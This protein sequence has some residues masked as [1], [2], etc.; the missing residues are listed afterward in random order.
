MAPGREAS[1]FVV[2]ALALVLGCSAPPRSP[3]NWSVA[4]DPGDGVSVSGVW[5]SAPEDVFAVGGGETGAVFHF[6]GKAW[7]RME[8]PAGSGLLAWVFGFGRDDVYAVGLHGLVLHYDGHA[9]T[10]LE[11]GTDA[12]LWG[13]FG[14]AKNDV[15]MVGGDPFAGPP[16]LLHFDGTTFT[17]VTLPAS[18]NPVHALSLFK[19]WGIGGRTWAVGQRGLIVELV[20]GAWKRQPAGSLADEDFISLWGVDAAHVTAV[21]GR[22]NARVARFDGSTWDTVAPSALGGLNAVFAWP[23][24]SVF[25]GGTSG[26]AGVLDRATGKVTKDTTGTHID[27]HAM[28]GDGKGHLYA[29]GGNFISPFQG[30]AL[31]RA[32]P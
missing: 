6:D 9:W 30:I 24:G 16:L 7:S 26:V 23:D 14:H 1:P 22:G 3:A 25:A 17:Q 19:V 31:V 32:V 28:W 8:L 2:L 4:F 20:D 11:T 5:G 29:V 10:R 27:V 15:W 12:Q 18:E 21:G 13:V